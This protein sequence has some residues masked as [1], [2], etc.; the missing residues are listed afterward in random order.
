MAEEKEGAKEGAKK[1]GLAAKAASMAGSA[2]SYVGKEMILKGSMQAA[3]RLIPQGAGEAA[4]ALFR[5][6]AFVQYGQSSYANQESE[7]RA[8][9][10]AEKQSESKSESAKAEPT[11]GMDDQAKATVHGA[12]EKLADNGVKAEG[13]EAAMEPKGWPDDDLPVEERQQVRGRGR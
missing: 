3:E 4:S 12:G 7:D 10:E 2:A 1:P 5:G 11:Q 6:D 13:K 9:N 8:M